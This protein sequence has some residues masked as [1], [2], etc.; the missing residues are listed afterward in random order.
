MAKNLFDLSS[1]R[2]AIK[3][4]TEAL[5]CKTDTDKSFLPQEGSITV[6]KL[7]GCPHSIEAGKTVANIPRAR[8]FYVHEDLD[9]DRDKIKRVLAEHTTLQ[10]SPHTTFPIV[11]VGTHPI[12]GN[13]ELQAFLRTKT[14]SAPATAHQA[15]TGGRRRRGSQTVRR[16]IIR[17]KKASVRNRKVHK[18]KIL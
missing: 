14:G 15:V 16:R 13:A 12:G 17:S 5:P 9:L 3:R 10:P 11:F 1:F 18:R 8:H 7:E 6:Y 4:H 2:A